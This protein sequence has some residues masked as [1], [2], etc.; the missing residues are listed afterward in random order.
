MQ[1]FTQW[2]VIGRG[3]ERVCFQNPDD[4]TRCI[5]VSRKHKAKQSRR[6]IRYL[7]YLLK[8]GVA[9]THIPAFY[10]V[11]ETDDYIGMEQ[12]LVTNPSGTPP[13]DL[14]YYLEQPLNTDQQAAFWQAMQSL[15]DYLLEYNVIPCD[16][17]MSNMLVVEDDNQIKV[18]M[19]DGFGGAEL[20]P[21]ANYIRY[22]GK[23]KIERKWR[24]FMER[25]LKPHFKRQQTL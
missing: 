19:I 1:D 3:D 2:K 8:R 6:E 4:P 21:L 12:E 18:M 23:R 17:V 22:F 20:I 13:L 24:E 16:L 7:Q 15:K 25:T 14:R 9:F 11:I 10:Q 5:K